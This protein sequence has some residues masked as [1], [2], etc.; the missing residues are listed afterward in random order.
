MEEKIAYMFCLGKHFQ[1][2]GGKGLAADTVDFIFS[3][4][5]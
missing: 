1:N 2:C 3:Y 4:A 5:Y